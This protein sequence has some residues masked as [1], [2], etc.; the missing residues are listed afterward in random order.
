MTSSG[1]KQ[2]DGREAVRACR[3]MIQ[4]WNYTHSDRLWAPPEDYKI[5]E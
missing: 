1:D 4:E 3:R 5:G 2:Q